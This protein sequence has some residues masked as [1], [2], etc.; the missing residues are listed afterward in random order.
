MEHREGQIKCVCSRLFFFY[1]SVTL[2]ELPTL[3]LNSSLVTE[4]KRHIIQ[5]TP[6]IRHW[7]NTGSCHVY[8]HLSPDGQWTLTSKT[9]QKSWNP[10]SRTT[11]HQSQRHLPYT[12][13]L[14]I[15]AYWKFPSSPVVRIP[16]SHCW[17][18]GSI[19][20]RETVIPQATQR[21]KKKK[22]L[23]T[24]ELKTNTQR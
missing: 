22:G 21:K 11:G 24:W 1:L 19:S 7:T 23:S 12:Q 18:P 5:R 15:N 9:A 6:Q 10:V 16:H 4:I 3:S 17:S 8:S 13:W 20:G 14:S 2:S